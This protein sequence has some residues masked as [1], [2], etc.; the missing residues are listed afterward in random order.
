VR[1]LG[2]RGMGQKRRKGPKGEKGNCNGEK[3]RDRKAMREG[4]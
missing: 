4:E 3:R 1:G 2:R